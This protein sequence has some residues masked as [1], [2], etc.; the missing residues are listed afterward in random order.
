MRITITT[1]TL[2]VLQMS[3]RAANSGSDYIAAVVNGDVITFSQVRAQSVSEVA[4]FRETLKGEQAGRAI[5]TLRESLLNRMID[6]LVFLQEL[7]RRGVS[8]LA[9]W[10]DEQKEAAIKGRFGGDRQQWLARLKQKAYIKTFGTLLEDCQDLE[11]TRSGEPVSRWSGLPL[12]Q[13]GHPVLSSP[14]LGEEPFVLSLQRK[15]SEP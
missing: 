3:C 1:L 2:V 5:K 11:S 8:L 6:R 7:K 12:T 13:D 9:D 10:T 14:P 15:P 4:R